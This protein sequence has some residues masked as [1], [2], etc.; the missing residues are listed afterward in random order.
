[1]KS[2]PQKIH[3]SIMVEYL[4]VASALVVVLYVLIGNPGSWNSSDPDAVG[5]ASLLHALDDRQ[6]KFADSINQP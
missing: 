4:I 3:G 5:K 2:S 1:M 6:H